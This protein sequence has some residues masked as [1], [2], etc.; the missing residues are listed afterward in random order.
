MEPAND[1][2]PFSRCFFVGL[3]LTMLL[4]PIYG[5]YTYLFTFYT[6]P[7]YGWWWSEI[8]EL[9]YLFIVGVV[10]A[11]ATVRLPAEPDRLP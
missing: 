6:A 8:P 5:L 10:T 7:S 9:R 3:V 1:A 4:H 11:L 2:L